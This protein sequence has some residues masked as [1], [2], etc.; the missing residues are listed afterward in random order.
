MKLGVCAG[1]DSAQAV[2]DAGYDYI[3][4]GLHV[5]AKMSREQ[6]VQN[7]EYLDDCNIKMEAT[8]LFF[9]G[10]IHLAGEDADLQKIS[11]YVHR[12]FDN[13]VFLGV[14]TCV[15]GSGG[16]RRIPDGI[17]RKRGYEQVLKAV[18]T[19]GEIAKD[20]GITI[21]IE[22][23][24]SLESNVFTTVRESLEACRVIGLDTVCVLADIYHMFM[25]K[26]DFSILP[27]AGDRL[28]HIHFSHPLNYSESKRVYPFEGDEYD[29]APFA[30]AL[31]Q[32]GYCGRISIEAGT[33]DIRNDAAKS[34]GL[35]KKLFCE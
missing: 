31:R 16:S 15:L 3:E 2:S 5:I 25:E 14:Q 19:A 4:G 10:E 27:I 24:N 18:R 33:K 11:D 7:K 13:A 17:E 6:L 28:K 20:Y 34:F 32:A 1:I 30:D 8:N 12:A 35:M 29:Y 26:E 9:P 23:L 22:P 21:A